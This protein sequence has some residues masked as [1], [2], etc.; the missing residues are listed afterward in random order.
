MSTEKNPEVKKRRSTS[1]PFIIIVVILG[2]VG[3]FRGEQI[4]TYTM[5]LQEKW[6]HDRKVAEDQRYDKAMG[7]PSEGDYGWVAPDAPEE[8]GD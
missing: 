2:L 6:S 3:Y 4:M 5:Y 8:K 7:P 1:I